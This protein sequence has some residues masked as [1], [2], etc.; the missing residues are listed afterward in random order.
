MELR[1]FTPAEANDALP[2]VRPLVESMVAAKRALDQAQERRDEAARSI[3]GNGGGI[4]PHELAALQDEVGRR[5]DELAGIVTELQEL[6]I[7]VKDLDAGLVDFP[8]RREGE[9]VLLC[10]RLGEEEVSFWHGLE[11][12]FAGRRPIDEL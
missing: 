3:A 9:D 8:C 1:H 6:G 10:W 12:G 4:P 11:G 7:L 2:Q 5:A